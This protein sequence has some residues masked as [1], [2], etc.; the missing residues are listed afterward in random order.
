MAGVGEAAQPAPKR[1][2]L[3]CKGNGL[4]PGRSYELPFPRIWKH[5][6]SEREPDDGRRLAGVFPPGDKI[7]T[8]WSHA[9]S[10]LQEFPLSPTTLEM[11]ELY[12]VVPENVTIR[13]MRRLLGLLPK[14]PAHSFV[15]NGSW[16]SLSIEVRWTKRREAA[17]VKLTSRGNYY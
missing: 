6:E 10:L 11:K 1:R 2:R 17:R 9:S 16:H 12:P 14:S 15:Y 5:V 13:E 8:W 7:T 3:T 4:P